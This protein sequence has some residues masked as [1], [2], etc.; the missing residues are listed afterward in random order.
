MEKKLIIVFDFIFIII[1]ILIIFFS[2]LLINIKLVNYLNLKKIEIIKDIEN[3]TG[4][5][6]DYK[7]ISPYII[8]KIK[9]HEVTLWQNST[10]L[11]LGNAI[12][13]YSIISLLFKPK[14]YLSIIKKIEFNTINLELKKD[15]LINNIN[16]LKNK[17]NNNQFKFRKK[18]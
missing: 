8:G 5:E 6:I 13:D 14:D 10:K 18:F 1:I 2:L 11:E 17:S 12:F 7:R 16:N 3:K 4:Y 9:V 15:D